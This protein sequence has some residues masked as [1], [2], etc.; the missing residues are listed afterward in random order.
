MKISALLQTKSGMRAKSHDE[1]VEHRAH[2]E[3]GPRCCPARR[4]RSGRGPP[5][6]IGLCAR[7]A[8]TAK[9]DDEHH[10]ATPISA[11]LPKLLFCQ[12]RLN[13]TPRFQA[14]AISSKPGDDGVVVPV[15]LLASNRRF[16][17][18]STR[19]ADSDGHGREPGAR[20]GSESRPADLTQ[21]G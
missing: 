21:A 13:E 1:E 2:A 6:T 5:H 16:I 7:Q 10:H 12:N 15:V 19:S 8:R 11:A 20:R 14:S 18:I 9:V 17:A 4:P 3:R